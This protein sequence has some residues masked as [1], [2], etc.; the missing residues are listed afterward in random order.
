M[1]ANAM[2]IFVCLGFLPAG[3]TV[4]EVG[5][6]FPVVGQETSISLPDGTR[7]LEMTYQPEASEQVEKTE[8]HV[9][10][11]RE[12]IPWTPARAGV[13]KIEAKAEKESLGEIVVSVRFDGVPLGGVVI[14]LVSAMLL[15]GGALISLKTLF[16][17][18][19]N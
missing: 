14:C 19:V 17:S 2:M 18:E 3:N 9:V 12:S 1:I 11:G 5:E 4:L 13:V 10:E 15:F 7:L 16:R 8:Q 6:K